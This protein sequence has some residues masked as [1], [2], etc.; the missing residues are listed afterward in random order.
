MAVMAIMLTVFLGFHVYIT[1]KGMTT[2][3]YFKWKEV[4]KWHKQAKRRFEDA[5]KEGLALETE[6]HPKITVVDEADVGCIGQK[7]TSGST[8]SHG[9]NS[10]NEEMSEKVNFIDP[11]PFPRNIYSRGLIENFTE[12]FH[13]L[14]LRK[15][16]LQRWQ[17]TMRGKPDKLEPKQDP[18]EKPKNI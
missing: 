8:N 9:E 2:N 15:D 11:G 1:A 7:D 6:F 14:S 5:K 16:A 18:K 17:E 3:E 13:P 10:G 12:V 4:R